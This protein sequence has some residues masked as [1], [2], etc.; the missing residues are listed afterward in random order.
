M[1]SLLNFSSNKLSKRAFRVRRPQLFKQQASKTRISC[2]VPQLFLQQVCKTRVSFEPSSTFQATSFQ[3]EHFVRGLFNFTSNKLPKRAFP[4]KPPQ[5]FKQQAFKTSIS[6][7]AS[8]TFQST[9]FQNKHFVRSLLNFSSNKLPKRAFC[10][11]PPQ[12]FKQQTSKTSISC[13]V[14]Q[15]FLQQ[16]CKTSASCKA[17][18]TFQATSFQKEHFVRGLF[19]FSSNKLQKRAFPPRPPPLLR[20]QAFKTSI[21]CEAFSTFQST[22][23]QNEHFVRSLL[24]FSSNKLPKQAFCARHLQLFKQQ[25]S[26]TSILCEASSTTQATSFQNEHFLRGTSTFQATSFQNEHFVRSLLNFSINKLPKQ[27][28]RA[29]PLQLFKQQASKTSISCEASLTFQ[30]TSFQNERFVRG[31]FNF[32]SNKLPKRAFRAKPPQL[33]NQQASKTSILCEA[34]ST[35]QATSFQN[36]RF[37][38]GLLNFSNKKLPKSCAC[39]AKR[40]NFC[41][42]SS[43]ARPP[44]DVPRNSFAEDVSRNNFGSLSARPPARPK[45][46]PEIV[47]P[48]FPRPPARPATR[49]L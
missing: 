18:S 41:S 9:S 37:V 30:A 16:A 12:L 23:F 28:F 7:E 40:N 38:R 11:R 24:N 5:P 47:L 26:K 25:A 35:F 21:S 19:N 45:T 2:E 10:A 27:A 43:P 15:L 32:S 4:A 46:C 42:L 6:C 22:S 14:P 13:E 49:S 36:E 31:L 33:F 34:S 39:H 20:Q 29:R 1:R 17:S 48:S 3:K 44:G 8:S